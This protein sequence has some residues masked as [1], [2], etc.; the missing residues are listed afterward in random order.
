MENLKVLAEANRNF[1]GLI[2]DAEECK[3]SNCVAPNQV[4]YS[5][6]YCHKEKAIRALGWGFW[7]GE[8]MK[9]S[10]ELTE[11]IIKHNTRPSISLIS[12]E[13][14]RQIEKEGYDA[15]HDANEANGELASAAACYAMPAD[16]RRISGSGHPA[17]RPW[18]WPWDTKFWKP[19]PKDRVREL[20]KAGAL[21]VA[22]IDRIMKEKKSK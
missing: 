12:A 2:L 18:Y 21:I 17:N 13:R 9:K 11:F 7:Y 6:E 1:V 14:E 8:Q 16:R 20:V 15:D 3:C 10:G 22:E 4:C 5:G 19:T